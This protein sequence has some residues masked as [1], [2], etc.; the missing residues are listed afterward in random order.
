[1]GRRLEKGAY[2]SFETYSA[3]MICTYT[4]LRPVGRSA[5]AYKWRITTIGLE[6]ILA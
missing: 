4:Q 3:H 5:A 2:I 1:M 6:T